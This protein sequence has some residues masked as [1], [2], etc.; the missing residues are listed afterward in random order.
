MT[1]LD[2]NPNAGDFRRAGA[3]LAGWA[4]KDIAA[5]QIALRDANAEHRNFQ[6]LGAL[7]ETLTRATGV[8]DDPERLAALR[9][10]IAR[11]AA[12]EAQEE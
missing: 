2:P 8:R 9:L 5:V 6:V 12:E 7:L 3:M 1:T 11:Y 10:D 4:T